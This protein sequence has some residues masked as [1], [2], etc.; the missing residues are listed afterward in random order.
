MQP[1]NDQ[2]NFI[3]NPNAQKK[4]PS[5]VPTPTG[6]TQRVLLIVG[7]IT[8]VVM[9]LV[10]GFSLFSRIGKVDNQDLIRAQAYQT[11]IL[12]IVDIGQ[13][14]VKTDR[15]RTE[16]ATLRA[17]T[18]SD[19][20]T[21]ADILIKRKETVT[22]LQLNAKKNADLEGALAKAK[23]TGAYDSAFEAALQDTVAAYYKEL[24]SAL[25]EATTQIEK[26]ALKNA[27]ANIEA[28]AK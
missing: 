16:I 8:I 7:V 17:T 23:E 27:V 10:V 13:K 1:Q 28:Y 14:E 6:T 5:L 12:R 21:L 20:T 3:L 2:Y 26:D 15:I 11:E 22:A 24:Q 25:A 9:L 4:K 19:L 18:Q